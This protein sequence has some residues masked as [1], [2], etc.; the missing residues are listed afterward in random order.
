MSMERTYCSIPSESWEVKAISSDLRSEAT[1]EEG[2]ALTSKDEE[3]IE[4]YV[5]AMLMVLTL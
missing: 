5:R 4:Q 1:E 3:G 2:I